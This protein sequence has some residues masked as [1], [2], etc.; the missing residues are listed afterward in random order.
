M[1]E[2]ALINRYFGSTISEPSMGVVRGIGDDCA[3]LSVPAGSELAISIDTAVEGAH[4]PTGAAPQDIATRAFCTA[5]SDLA[6]M[7]ATP[8]W[9][10]LALTLP[11]A[12]ESWLK[13]FSESLKQL[14][15]RFNCI[16]VGGDTTRGPLTVSVQVHGSVPAGQ[17]L[18]RA[19]AKVGDAVY[20]SNTLGIGAAALASIQ[21]ELNVPAND[22]ATLKKHF[23]A[24]EPQIALGQWLRGKATSAIDVSDGL[25]VDTQH[26][27]NASNVGIELNIDTLPSDRYWRQAVTNEQALQWMLTGGDEY[28]LVFTASQMQNDLEA[29]A[30]KKNFNLT[31]IG[32]VIAGQGVQLM[33]ANQPVFLQDMGFNTEG[34]NHF[35]G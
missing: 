27:A 12:D 6:A 23:Y 9:V 1:D 11:Q 10:T 8:L 32:Q 20:V 24:P 26:I 25:I 18:T 21:G 13:A 30:A 35:G 34:F 3:L 2:F 31:R 7:G 15:T 4:F 22:A 28:Q 17:A 19:K 16:L 5:L 14:L 29:Q 33:Q